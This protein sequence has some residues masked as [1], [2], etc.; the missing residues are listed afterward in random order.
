[1]GLLSNLFGTPVPS[2]NVL[3]LHK[4]LAGQE[5]FLLLDV[6]EPD[7]YASGHI[8]NAR[9]L[10]LGELGKRLNELPRDRQVVCICASGNRSVT[11]T[12]ALMAA[13][14]NAINVKNGMF[15]WQMMNLPV[16]TG[17]SGALKR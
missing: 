15:A 17:M 8:T 11:A 12:R 6:R 2:I 1:M 7:E 9:L 3:E 16:D 5:Q 10:P 4:K 14:Y 13:G